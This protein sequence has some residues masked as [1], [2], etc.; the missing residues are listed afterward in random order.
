MSKAEMAVTTQSSSRKRETEAW[1]T[2]SDD[3]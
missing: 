1:A 2:Q 3:A